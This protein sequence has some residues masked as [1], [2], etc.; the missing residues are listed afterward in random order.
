LQGHRVSR[1]LH[2]TPETVVCNP[3]AT[4]IRAP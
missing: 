1:P 3:R 2:E 4:Q